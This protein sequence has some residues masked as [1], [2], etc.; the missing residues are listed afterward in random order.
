MR[1]FVIFGGAFAIGMFASAFWKYPPVTSGDVASWMQ[2][3]GSITGIALALYLPWRQRVR[4]MNAQFEREMR[5]RRA[6]YDRIIKASD[7]LL[8]ICTSLPGRSIENDVDWASEIEE[9][10]GFIDTVE[11]IDRDDDGAHTSPLPG[12]MRTLA[13]RVRA[14]LKGLSNMRNR[15]VGLHMEEPQMW[16]ESATQLVFVAR[17]EFNAAFPI[18]A[19]TTNSGN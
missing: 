4:E 8:R 13:V 9:L 3:F 2:A 17:E 14:R 6:V 15:S 10:T 12:H 11:Q 18:P 1:C 16:L 7:D 19:P 5:K